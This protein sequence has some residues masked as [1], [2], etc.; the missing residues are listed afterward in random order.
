MAVET[1][2]K[3][4]IAPGDVRRLAGHPLLAEVPAGRQRLLNTYYDTP[5]LRLSKSGVAVRFRKKGA[6]WLLTVKS[7][8]SAS[9]GLARRSECEYPAEPGNFDFR[10]VDDPELRERLE[11]EIPRL[12]PIFTT[13]F[14]RTSRRLEFQGARIELAIDRGNIASGGQRR[15][16]CELE[17]ELLEGEIG[18]LLAFARALQADIPLRPSVASKAEHGYRLHLG[19]APQ[20]FRAVSPP[21][22]KAM[23]PVEAFRC[24]AFG[25]LEQ[26]QRNEVVG[27]A[28][29]DPEFVHQARVALRRL[30]S[31]LKL[32]K[33]VLPPGFVATHGEVWKRLAAALGDARN[34]DVFVS[35]TL[36]PLERAFPDNRHVRRL[37]REG[38]RR[39]AMAR[40]AV[41]ALFSGQD[42]CRA[43]LA[44]T[45]D[46]LALPDN[47]DAA[48]PEFAR[49]RLRRHA[50][51]AER[52]ARR[53]EGEVDLANWHRL[54]IAF[55]KLRYALEFF[56][57]LMPKRQWKPYLA[58]LAGIQ[59]ELGLLNDHGTAEALVREVLGEGKAGPVY[60]WIAGRCDLLVGRLPQ[61]LA[62]WSVA[63][64]PWKRR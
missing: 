28:Q 36:P 12:T 49:M 9:G 40:R 64:G 39:A 62:R 24:V 13:D 63:R 8:E 41:E 52:L 25:C 20:P 22:S 43:V 57:P 33:P 4:L 23:S 45:A 21:L 51:S 42:Y 2:L 46:L 60:G 53:G 5:D 18:P 19:L 11:A 61:A 30:R 48:L 55:K 1:E 34:W 56:A 59:G 16:I 38:R 37:R 10:F 31:A 54:R 58:S 47:R 44:F 6:A 26:L 7:A 15:N 32:F 35:E 50:R 17:L 3:L 29:S 14:V 27:A